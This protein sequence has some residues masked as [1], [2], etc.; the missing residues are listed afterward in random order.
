MGFLDRVHAPR[1]EDHG[2]TDEWWY[3]P[4]EWLTAFR[5]TG[6]RVTP[7]LAMTVSAIWAGVTFVSRNLGSF[8][9]IT[10]ERMSD[11]ERQRARHRPIYDVLRWQP[12]Q[13][14]TSEEFWEMQVG[15]LLLRGNAYSRILDGPRG[16]VD[17][18]IP[19]HPDRVMAERLPSGRL[20]YQL[21]KPDGSRD[22]LTQDQVFHIRGFSSDGVTGL[23]LTAMAARSIG[24]AIAADSYAARFFKQGATPSI[25]V[26]HPETLG[27]EGRKNVQRS[28][29][30]Y[31]TGLKR[32]HGILVLEEGMDVEK[33]GIN[34]QEAQLLPTREHVVREVA[35]WLGLP[36]QVLADNGKT[37]TFASAEVFALSLITQ[38]FRPLAVRIEQAIRRD[39]I[40]DQDRFFVEFLMDALLRG[41]MKARAAFNRMAIMAGWMTRNEVRA[42]ENMNPGPP[43]LDKF[44]E[45]LNMVPAGE[46][47]ATQ[48]SGRRGTT[49]ARFGVR[50]TMLAMEA[51]GRVVRRERERVERAAKKH[52]SDGEGWSTWLRTFYGEHAEYVAETLKIPLPVA[53]DYAARQGLLLQ[54]SESGIEIMADWE[55][56]VTPDLAALALG[57]EGQQQVFLGPPPVV[58]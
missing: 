3:G 32:A 10:Y 13:I 54:Q 12:N 20:R 52:A 11:T 18:L 2:P 37:P 24:A 1:S 14:Q 39:L 16:A 17:T 43:E 15:H 47:D 57:G 5:E 22:T 6:I 51:A 4:A 34:P 9:C 28:L 42:K 40:V 33:L 49:E 48:P 46:R 7:E 53:R 27:D 23:S 26:K 21:A 36:T 41:D 19:L 44:F 30:G 8:P 25:V 45:P 31:L 50:A 55:W 58:V 35:R 38:T 56:T 29:N